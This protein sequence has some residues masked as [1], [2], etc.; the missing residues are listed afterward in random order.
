MCWPGC[1][2]RPHVCAECCWPIYPTTCHINKCHYWHTSLFHW[3]LRRLC[4]FEFVI[5]TLWEYIIITPDSAKSELIRFHLWH[6]ATTTHVA[7]MKLYTWV[8]CVFYCKQPVG[9]GCSSDMIFSHY[10]SCL[11]CPPHLTQ[12]QGKRTVMVDHLD[13]EI[14]NPVSHIPKDQFYRS[15]PHLVLSLQVQWATGKSVNF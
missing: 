5:L 1:G 6:W 10:S 12:H 13:S 15:L 4:P 11:P 7:C 9:I 14:Y 2:I 8:C 3:L